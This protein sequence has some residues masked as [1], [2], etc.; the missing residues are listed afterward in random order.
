[1]TNGTSRMLDGM[2][3][4]LSGGDEEEKV[5]HLESE[6]KSLKELVALYKEKLDG[7]KEKATKKSS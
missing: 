5:R 7:L 6:N 1:M 3:K 4:A 2:D